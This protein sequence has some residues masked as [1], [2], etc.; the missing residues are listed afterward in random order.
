MPKILEERVAALM[1]KGMDRERAYAI[2]T[3]SLQ[4]EGKMERGSQKLTSKGSKSKKRKK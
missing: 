1:R 3:S 2:A 4:K